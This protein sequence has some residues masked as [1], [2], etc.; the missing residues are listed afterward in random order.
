MKTIWIWSGI[1]K[2]AGAALTA[3]AVAF[4]LVLLL[5]PG[6]VGGLAIGMALGMPTGLIATQLW[7]CWRFEW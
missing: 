7:P 3:G 1:A 5:K 6:L 2:L 4:G